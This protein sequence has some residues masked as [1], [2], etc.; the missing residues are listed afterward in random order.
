[1]SDSFFLKWSRAIKDRGEASLYAS[2][3]GGKRIEAV[4]RAICQAR[5]FAFCDK[6]CV[7]GCKGSEDTIYENGS[8]DLACAAVLA[9]DRYDQH[10]Q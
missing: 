8:F 10:K 4:A 2:E 9:L 7:H 5:K 3:E 6:H 1:M